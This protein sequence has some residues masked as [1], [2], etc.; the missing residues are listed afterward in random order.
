MQRMYQNE[1]QGIQFEEFANLSS[2]QLADGQFY[3]K[4]Y[5]AFFDRYRSWDDID[6][7][8]RNQKKIVAGFLL[9][10]IQH[11]KSEREREEKAG[12]CRLV[13]V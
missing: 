2:T 10:L 9:S 8:W 13:A 1:W 7:D 5:K 6:H 11:V 4:F 3:E 12:Y